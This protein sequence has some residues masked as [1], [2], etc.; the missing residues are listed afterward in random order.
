MKRVCDG[1]EE[2]VSSISV[3]KDLLKDVPTSDLC[4]HIGKDGVK[5]L[6]THLD[7]AEA[8]ANEVLEFLEISPLRN[9]RDIAIGDHFEYRGQEYRCELDSDVTKSGCS[10]CDLGGGFC[11]LVLCKRKFRRDRVNVVFKK[12]K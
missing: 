5:D 11:S 9:V 6:Y 2:F 12:L 7:E 3:I 1:L 10:A 8:Y 4:K